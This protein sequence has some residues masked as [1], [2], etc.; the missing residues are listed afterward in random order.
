VG[1]FGAFE[2]EEL[3]KPR[4]RGRWLKRS[5]GLLVVL[6][7]AGGG[8]YGAY[9]WTQTQYYVG[10][11]GDHAAIYQGIEQKLAWI[12][13]SKVHEDRPGIELK[14]LP[15]NQRKY[16]TATIAASGL[17]DARRTADELEH[18]AEVCQTKEAIDKSAAAAADKAKK[19]EQKGADTA[20]GKTAGNP[21][22]DASESPKPPTSPS[23]SPSTGPTLSDEDQALAEQC[24]TGS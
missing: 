6:G 14:Y 4:K 11:K 8:L 20:V 2:D 12:D 1:G 17:S 9:R 24:P 10:V 7:V 16:V 13:L 18:Q 5:L 3:S 19:D 15:Q 22:S 23:T 21:S